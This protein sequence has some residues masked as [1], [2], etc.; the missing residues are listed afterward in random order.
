MFRSFHVRRAAHAKPPR[1]FLERLEERSVPSTTPWTSYA[2]NPQHTATSTVASQ[3]LDLIHWQTPVDLNPQY[4]GNDLLIHYGS[5]LVTAANTVIVPV[6]TGASAGYEV[7]GVNGADGTV[8]WTQT[9]DYILPPH[10]WVPSFS[11]VLTPKNRLYYA[12]AGGTI[13]YIDS[14]DGTGAPVVKQLAFYGLANYNPATFNNTVFINT[15]ITSDAQG[16]LYFGFQAASGAPLG[17]KS[18]IARIGADGTGSWVAATTAANDA[19]IVKVVMNN[20]PAVSNDGSTIYVA[21]SAGN[22]SWGY[23]LELNSSTLATV[24]KVALKDVAHP[25]NNANLPDDGTASTTVGPDGDVYFGVLENPFPSNNDRG[26]LL[27]FSGDLSQA[28]TPGA[29][30]WDDTASIVPKAMVPSYQGNS[31]YL[32]MTKYNNYAGVGTGDGQNKIAVLDPNAT[33]TDPVTGATVMKE[34]LTILGQTPDSE[35]PGGVR[36]WCINTAVVDPF[37]KTILANSEDGKLYRWD[38]TTNTFTQV[39]TLTSGIG[40]AYTPTVIGVDGTVYAIN[41]AT[42]FAVG[43]T[44]ITPF[45]AHINFSNN[46]TQVP[47]GYVNDTGLA[48]GS[49]NNG[50]TFGWNIDNT[51]NMR[52]RDSS[53]SPDELHDSLGHMQRSSNPNASWEIAVPNGVY[54]VHLIAGDP[55]YIDS[56]YKI[57]VEGVLA[58]NGTPTNSSHWVENTVQV[59]VSDGKLTVSNASGSSNNKIDEIDI[60]RVQ[61]TLP[62]APTNV[63]ATTGSQQVTLNW[64]ASPGGFTYNI[65]RSLTSLGEGSTPIATGVQGT[66]F[67][68]MGLTNG[69]TYYYQVTAVNLNGESAKSME[70]SATP[71]ASNFVAHVNFSNNNTQVPAGYINDVGLVYGQ[72][73]NGQT[74][75]WNMDNSANMRD[76]DSSLSPD[77]LHDSLGHMQKS[78]NPNAFW[79]IAVPNGTYSVHLIAGDPT[80]IDSV[81]KINVEGVL[82]ING[83]PNSSTLWFENTLQVTVTDGRLTISNAAGSSNNKIDEIDITQVG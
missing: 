54:T 38:M 70:V 6:K 39:V 52:D 45:T 22:F 79:E 17:L 36:E 12:G 55:G 48:Y 5:P 11:P 58:I 3:S 32:L 59:A 64:T 20:A 26:W 62:P 82:G 75:G 29:F 18:G 42:L 30:G 40:E 13:Y 61:P 1:L 35:H 44:P 69:T 47:S 72:R 49:R 77:E 56:V 25:A 66:S 31:S 53:L 43:A 51:V 4:S 63:T 19:G 9:T 21:V 65:Y 16:N 33:E 34:V 24:A 15:P 14:P 80:A 27:H 10:N 28:K 83:V 2:G 8:K 37:T 50:Q 81:Y 68:D 7:E 78:S 60:T 76:R 73:S 57:N 71:V 46:T 41:N 67:T 74:F 23:L